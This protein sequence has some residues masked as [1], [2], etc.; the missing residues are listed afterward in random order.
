VTQ[1][2]LK[3]GLH[4]S[5]S[6]ALR[7]A[8]V[9]ADRVGQTTG[10][11]RAS[12]GTHEPDGTVNGHEY[13]A[14]TDIRIGGMSEA[15][16]KALADKLS[17][18]G[19]AC[20]PRYPGR[21]HWGASEVKHMHIVYGGCA[22]KQVLRRQVH[23]FCHSPQMLNGLASHAPY[24]FWHPQEASVQVVRTLFLAHNPTNG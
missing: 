23:D 7:K 16:V 15:E 3:A 11:A 14:A 18:Q 19:F 4:P 12:A 8:G 21:D 6:D 2:L 13:S 17:A 22:M 24:T 9:T 1:P 10:H 5:A 20:F